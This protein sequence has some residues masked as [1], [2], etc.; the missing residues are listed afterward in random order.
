MIMNRE[1]AIRDY[2]E[3]L[4][5]QDINNLADYV[6]AFTNQFTEVEWYPMDYFNEMYGG[7]PPFDIA[8]MV[9]M[10]DFNPDNDWFRY[11]N[12]L[13]ST[14]DATMKDDVYAW[15][16]DLIDYFVAPGEEIFTGDSVLDR[17]INAPENAMFNDNY[18]RASET[19]KEG[20]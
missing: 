11:G 2:V 14:D 4:R 12:Y 15:A 13:E 19:S 1:Q 7:M 18:E 8:E 20:D 5:A 10:G 16:D 9:S 6:S 3:S 17:M